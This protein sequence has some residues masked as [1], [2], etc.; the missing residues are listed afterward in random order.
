MTA[1]LKLKL[2]LLQ[3]GQINIDSIFNLVFLLFCENNFLVIP[4]TIRPNR[5]RKL[6][7]TEVVC[8]KVGGSQDESTSSLTIT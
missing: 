8:K 2:E 1:L 5:E 7:D 3:D 6:V 4:K